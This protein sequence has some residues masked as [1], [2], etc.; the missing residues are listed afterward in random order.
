MSPGLLV[1]T[2][3]TVRTHQAAAAAAAAVVAVVESA[4]AAAVV[5]VAAVAAAAVVAAAPSFVERQLAWPVS[6]CRFVSVDASAVPSQ[7]MST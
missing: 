1:D 4:A 3:D 6:S 7:G 2:A 5:V